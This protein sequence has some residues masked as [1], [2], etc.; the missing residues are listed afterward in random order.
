LGLV[1]T[2]DGSRRLQVVQDHARIGD[3]PG[4]VLGSG[5]GGDF[6]EGVPVV[7][8]R[9]RLPDLVRWRLRGG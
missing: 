7:D 5:V 1:D 2:H 6:F 3:W 8:G 4:R 9:L